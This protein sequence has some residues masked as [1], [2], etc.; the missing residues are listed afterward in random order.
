MDE[1]TIRYFDDGSIHDWIR[2]EY[3]CGMEVAT[4]EG[5]FAGYG[6]TR[7]GNWYIHIARVILI[8]T[9]DIRSITLL[10]PAGCL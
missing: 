10:T 3:W 7:S 5:E 1:A 6:R 9:I 8:P 2:V 4:V